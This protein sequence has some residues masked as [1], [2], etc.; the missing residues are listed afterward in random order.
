MKSKTPIHTKLLWN[1]AKSLSRKCSSNELLLVC[2][3]KTHRSASS[4]WCAWEEHI[5]TQNTNY[6]IALISVVVE[7]LKCFLRK[8]KDNLIISWALGSIWRWLQQF[9]LQL[10]FYLMRNLLLGLLSK[11]TEGFFLSLQG[12]DRK[13][14]DVMQIQKQ[15]VFPFE[16][17]EEFISVVKLLH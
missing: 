2:E 6:L 9:Y 12:K 16:L 3:S 15:V 10:T 13:M 1:I 17:T 8:Q 11:F 7:W 5:L 14:K 4:M